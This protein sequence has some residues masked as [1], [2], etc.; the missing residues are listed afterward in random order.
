MGA[1]ED[2]MMMDRDMMEA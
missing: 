2:N 1:S